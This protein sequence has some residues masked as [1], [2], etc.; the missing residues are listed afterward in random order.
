MYRNNADIVNPVSELTESASQT[1][2]S[3]SV[4]PDGS[5]EN[6]TSVY[7]AIVYIGELRTCSVCPI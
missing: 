3:T 5:V 2:I 6:I 7:D 4:L 1:Y